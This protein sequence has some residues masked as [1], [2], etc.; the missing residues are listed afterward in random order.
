MPMYLGSE[1]GIRLLDIVDAGLAENYLGRKRRIR[2]IIINIVINKNTFMSPMQDRQ[3]STSTEVRQAT[4]L[5][6]PCKPG[7]RERIE[8]AF[9]GELPACCAQS[10]DY[11][12]LPLHPQ[13]HFRVTPKSLLSH[14]TPP[15]Q[16]LLLLLL[17]VPLSC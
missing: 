4:R 14:P 6:S 16:I 17:L 15:Y 9:L 13:G 7:Q 3:A 1:R 10:A 12:G 5:L 11:Y 8:A 2:V